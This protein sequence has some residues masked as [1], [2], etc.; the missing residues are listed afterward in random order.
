MERTMVALR[1]ST[2]YANSDYMDAYFSVNSHN[3]GRSTLDYYDADAGFKDVGLTCVISYQ[4]NKNWGATGVLGLTRL[5]G[6]A[7]DSP[8][9]DDAGDENQFLAGIMG[10]YRF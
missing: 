2:T 9:V 5:I 3:I 10:T 1:A 8:V 4:F 6:D 7:A